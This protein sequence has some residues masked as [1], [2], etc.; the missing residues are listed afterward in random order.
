MVTTRHFS[1]WFWCYNHR[2]STLIPFT[3]L[4]S[5]PTI[6]FFKNDL[7]IK[8]VMNLNNNRSG[9]INQEG[10]RFI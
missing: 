10:N 8:C 1:L 9:A 6:T 2:V 5:M 4:V 3:S 7:F